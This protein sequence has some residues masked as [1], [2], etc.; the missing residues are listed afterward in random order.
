MS[1]DQA[2][3]EVLTTNNDYCVIDN[4]TLK[5]KPFYRAGFSFYKPGSLRSTKQV[6][7]V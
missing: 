3:P 4:K 2:T 7:R 6:R 5:R 1:K